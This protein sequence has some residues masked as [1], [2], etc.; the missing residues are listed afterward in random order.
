[1]RE[2]F[3]TSCDYQGSVCQGLSINSYV[4]LLF[5]V[6]FELQDPMIKLRIPYDQMTRRHNQIKVNK[7]ITTTIRDATLYKYSV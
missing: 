6:S 4:S 7:T 5:Y 2:S 1:M 3:E